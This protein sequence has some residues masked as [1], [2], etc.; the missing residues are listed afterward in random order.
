MLL[1]SG[2]GNGIGLAA[3]KHTVEHCTPDYEA[4]AAR[5]KKRLDADSRALVGLKGLVT[6]GSGQHM[7]QD[8]SMVVCA[9]IGE[10][11]ISVPANQIEYEKLLKEIEK[12]D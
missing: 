3:E 11:S 12:T 4:M 1:N 9:V 6:E 5:L 8:Y 2:P 10:L 7:A